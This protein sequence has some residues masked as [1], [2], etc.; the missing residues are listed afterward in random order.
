MAQEEKIHILPS[1][2]MLEAEDCQ[3]EQWQQASNACG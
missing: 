3:I 2:L 1:Q